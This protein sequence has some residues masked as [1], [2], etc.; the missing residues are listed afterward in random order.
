VNAARI[1]A[2]R[3]EATRRIMASYLLV[4][5]LF[6]PRE[7]QRASERRP[8]SSNLPQAIP[9]KIDLLIS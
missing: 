3:P 7:A 1:P 4:S 6:L 9:R 5:C 8:H 2:T